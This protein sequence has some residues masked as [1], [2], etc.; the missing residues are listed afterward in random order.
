MAEVPVADVFVEMADTL[1]DDFDVMD[2][3]HLLAERSVTL[4]GASAAG[5]LLADEQGRLQVVAASSERTRLLGCFSCSRP[6][7]RRLFV[8]TR[9]NRCR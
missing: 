6:G 8:S 7:L 5:L 9:A 4:V 1:V 2:F 3:L